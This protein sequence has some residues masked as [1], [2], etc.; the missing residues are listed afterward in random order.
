MKTFKLVL[1]IILLI[2][3]IPFAIISIPAFILI[4]AI[5]GLNNLETKPRPKPAI[6]EFQLD[7]K[8]FEQVESDQ[9]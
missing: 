6:P 1:S 7:T 4:L 9:A 8:T 2:V 5:S 3:L